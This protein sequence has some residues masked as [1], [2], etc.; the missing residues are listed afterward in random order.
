MPLIKRV[1][2][3]HQFAAVCTSQFCRD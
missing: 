2:P 3:P 1:K